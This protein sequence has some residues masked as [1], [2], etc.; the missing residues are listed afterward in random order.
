[1]GKILSFEEKKNIFLNK[2][3]ERY[4]KQ[5]PE[6]NFR[7]KEDTDFVSNDDFVYISF[8]IEGQTYDWKTKPRYMD[9]KRRPLELKNYL[10]KKNNVKNRG[11][12]RLTH[13]EFLNKFYNKFNKDDYEV[14]NEYK[15]MHEKIQIKHLKCGKV[16]E[17]EPSNLLYKSTRGCTFCFS[18]KKKSLEEYQEIFSNND[19]LKE[20]KINKIF[21]KDSHIYANITHLS[22]KCEFYNYSAR[23]SDLISSHKQRCPKCNEMKKESKACSEI[24]KYLIDNNIKFQKEVKFDNLKFLGDLKIDFFLEDYNLCIEYDGQQH[25][26]RGFNKTE[27]EFQ[28]SKTRDKIKDNYFKNHEKYNLHRIKYNEN[29]IEKLKD[30]LAQYKLD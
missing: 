27:E 16:F 26:K 28:K 1:M 9:G 4:Q 23:I 8:D 6:F 22:K 20:Y 29:H 14:L 3:N 2:L 19:E 18:K 12:Q 10:D 13:E 11:P 7:I 5:Y 24:T 17:S 21:K 15:G 25:F 30:I